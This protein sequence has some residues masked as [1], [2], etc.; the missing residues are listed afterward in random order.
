M[1]QHNDFVMDR[2]PYPFIEIGPDDMKELNVNAGDLVDVYNDTGST[3]ASRLANS[4]CQ[5]LS[6]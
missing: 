3:Q 6:G 1:D 5:W 2:M 4:A